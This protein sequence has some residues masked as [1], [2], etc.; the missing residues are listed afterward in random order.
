MDSKPESNPLKESDS[1]QQPTS[2]GE[3]E[4]QTKVVELDSASDEESDGIK[5][6]KRRLIE[7]KR[8]TQG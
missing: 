3:F 6:E 5:L 2:G 4:S 8:K 7:P 1:S